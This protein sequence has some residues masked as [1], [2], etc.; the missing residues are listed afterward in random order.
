MNRL[1]S[2]AALSRLGAVQK[3]GFR[4]RGQ[5]DVD[6]ATPWYWAPFEA[7]NYSQLPER[8]DWYMYV[9]KRTKKS[10][11]YFIFSKK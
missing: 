4:Y 2:R 8:Y 9:K 3:R 11:I 5:S 7:P 10:S 6:T 1:I